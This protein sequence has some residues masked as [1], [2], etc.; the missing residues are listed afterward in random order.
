MFLLILGVTCLFL[1]NTFYQYLDEE[2]VLH[3]SFFLPLGWLSLIAGGLG[4]FITGIK[5]VW[6]CFRQDVADGT[7]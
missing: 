1:E 2:G 7:S 3:E 5:F 6:A 4:L